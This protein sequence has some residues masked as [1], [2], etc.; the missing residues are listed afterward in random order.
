[1]EVGQSV[2]LYFEK[3]SEIVIAIFAVR[4]FPSTRPGPRENEKQK[5]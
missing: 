5:I 1:M 3:L 4:P 2:S